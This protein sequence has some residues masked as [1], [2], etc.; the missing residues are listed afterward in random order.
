[1]FEAT[2]N[3]E[4]RIPAD[5]EFN[6]Q[7]RNPVDTCFEMNERT[8]V[9]ATFQVEGKVSYHNQLKGRNVADCHPKDSITGLTEDLDNLDGAINNE[10]LERQQEDENLQSQITSIST[11]AN[12]Y[13]HEQG[14]ASSIWLINHNMNKYP[15]VSVVDS[16]ENSL[17]VEVEYIDKNN[18][19]IKM[20]GAS[21]GRAYLN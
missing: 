16:A 21:K 4:E 15:S 11:I 1:M 14:I 17:I 18:V 6:S 12:G 13:V 2:F 3:I 5:V 7:E 20:N 10:T 8:P 9:E 19:K